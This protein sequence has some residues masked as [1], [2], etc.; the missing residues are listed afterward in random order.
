[1]MIKVERPPIGV[2]GSKGEDCVTLI[3]RPLLACLQQHS[4]NTLPLRH[5]TGRKFANIGLALA[6]KMGLMRDGCEAETLTLVF[7]GN[8]DHGFLVVLVE[9]SGDPA[10]N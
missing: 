8:E 5:L 2:A 10:F 9:T 4:A 3:T 6:S 7:F 1:M